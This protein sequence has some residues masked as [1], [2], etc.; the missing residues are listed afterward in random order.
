MYVPQTMFPLKVFW[1]LFLRGKGYRHRL[2]ADLCPRTFAARLQTL[3]GSPSPLSHQ[4]REW[5]QTH[6][7]SQIHC[8]LCTVFVHWAN[9]PQIADQPL[10]SFWVSCIFLIRFVIISCHVPKVSVRSDVN[11]FAERWQFFSLWFLFCEFL[12]S[13]LCSSSQLYLSTTEESKGPHGMA[14]PCSG[15]LK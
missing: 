8:I 13:D 9:L 4:I 7:T 1:R 14:Q 11:F 2:W 6:P 12:F 3:W 5:I 10:G 15:I